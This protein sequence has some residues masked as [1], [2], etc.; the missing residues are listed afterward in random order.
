MPLD[1]CHFLPFEG[2]LLPHEGVNPLGPLLDHIQKVIDPVLAYGPLLGVVLHGQHLADDGL[3][4][5]LDRLESSPG[6]LKIAAVHPLINMYYL[7]AKVAI[8]GQI[9]S[10]KFRS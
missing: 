4:Q 3:L 9:T 7:D 8:I 2:C 6:F 1:N 5:N 10:R